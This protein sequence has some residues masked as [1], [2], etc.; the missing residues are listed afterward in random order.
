LEWLKNLVFDPRAFLGRQPWEAWGIVLLQVLLIFL[1]AKLLAWAG[2]L[3]IGRLCHSLAG[4][5][6]FLEIR[7]L[8]LIK[9]VLQTLFTY[10][11]YLLALILTLHYFG[12]RIISP[13]DLKGFGSAVLKIALILLG[14]GLLA[15]FGKSSIENL[16]V[17]EKGKPGWQENRRL[18]TLKTLLR[19][20]WIYGT[21]FLA[22]LMV[23]ETIGVRTS[24]LIAGAGLV[25][26][27]IGFG[28]QSLVRDVITGFFITFEDQF[29]IGDLITTAGVTGTV[30]D[31]GLRTTRI[32]E[33]TGQLHII[34]NGEIT[35]VTNFSRGRMVAVVTVSI[36]Y[37]TD[38]D[39]ALEVLRAA[40]KEAKQELP[41]LVEEP[42]VH[43]VIE[44][45][46]AGL[47]VRIAALTLA[48][49][50]WMMERELRKRFKKALE[51]AGLGVAYPRHVVMHQGAKAV[52]E[53]AAPVR[54]AKED[55]TNT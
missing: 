12:G 35:I 10:G 18:Q 27:A 40:C 8:G 44:M 47:T 22:G 24:S 33:W 23:L 41:A 45:G 3:G 50:Q 16:F 49:E 25:G 48:G 5:G 20:V 13:E 14:A 54:G 1:A 37:E 29:T 2:R 19:S 52:K 55:E 46:D 17:E 21:F 15:K 4:K 34:P 30:E 26:L 28:A 36:S 38:I 7:H 32:R 51:A 53:A 39:Q 42:L 43:G 31:M 6:L 11:V 9:I